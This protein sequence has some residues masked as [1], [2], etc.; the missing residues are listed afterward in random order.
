MDFKLQNG[1]DLSEEQLDISN[2]SI[3]DAMMRMALHL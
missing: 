1:G 3:G 2:A